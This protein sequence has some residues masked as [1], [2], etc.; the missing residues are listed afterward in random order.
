MPLPRSHHAQSATAATALPDAV[1][2]GEGERDRTA[3]T[4]DPAQFCKLAAEALNA[5]L[6][7]QGKSP[8]LDG[9]HLR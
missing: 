8:A 5:C 3:M 6:L 4:D 9:T 7:T 2:F 1:A